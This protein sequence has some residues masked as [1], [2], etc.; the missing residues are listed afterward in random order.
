MIFNNDFILKCIFLYI[1]IIFT[2]SFTSCIFI[3]EDIS[4]SSSLLGE[5]YTNLSNNSNEAEKIYSYEPKPVSQAYKIYNLDGSSDNI[6]VH[7]YDTYVYSYE[8]ESKYLN[9]KGVEFNI[10]IL[11]GEVKIYQYLCNYKKCE[12]NFNSK[13]LNELFPIL[14]YLSFT[15]KADEIIDKLYSKNNNNQVYSIIIHCLNITG[16]NCSYGIKI[17]KIERY[18]KLNNGEKLLKYIK[19]DNAN[20]YI[21]DK[22]IIPLNTHSKTIFDL[23]VYSGDA[24]LLLTDGTYNDYNMD[25]TIQDLGLNQRAI[26]EPKNNDD[27]NYDNISFENKIHVRTNEGAI[28]YIYV[29][30]IPDD[31]ENKEVL[32]MEMTIMYSI[33]NSTNITLYSNLTNEENYY[34][35]FNPINCD[36]EINHFCENEKHMLITKEQNATIEYETMKSSIKYEIKKY[37]Q[38]HIDENKCFFMINSYYYNRNNSYIL[39]PESK[40]FRAI[41]NSDMDTIRMIF[42]FATTKKNPKILLR[43]SLYSLND[44][45]LTI[46]FGS[47]F[48]EQYCSQST[49]ILLSKENI[50]DIEELTINKSCPIIITAKYINNINDNNNN[51]VLDFNIKTLTN[52]P[53]FIKSEEF[54][55]DSVLNNNKQYYMS[56]LKK[57]STGFILLN[58][59]R[60][61]G[62]IYANIYK[63]SNKDEIRD[64]NG[65]II[66]PSDKP[67]DSFN[68]LEQKFFF[69]ESNTKD[70]DE[71]CYLIFGIT[72]SKMIEDETN[73]KNPKDENY[74]SEYSLVLKYLNKNEKI[75]NFIDLI[76][77]EFII[78]NIDDNENDFYQFNFP[79][80][81]NIN[82][83]IIDYQSEN[84]EIILCFNS[85]N[86]FNHD[87]CRTF[88][89]N[90]ENLIFKIKKEEIIS[91]Y[92]YNYNDTYYI[93]KIKIQL[94]N[95]IFKITNFDT[96]YKLRLTSPIDLFEKVATID[97]SLPVHCN[98]LIPT[99]NGFYSDY[100]ININKFQD[101]ELVQLY[102][103]SN[104]GTE[105][106]E[107]Y[108]KI[109]DSYNFLEKII[110]NEIIWPNKENN[111]YSSS[112]NHQPNILK[113]SVNKEQSIKI[114]IR[115]Y[116][117]QMFNIT[118]ITN[119]IRKNDFLFPVSNIKQLININNESTL[120][121][122]IPYNSSYNIQI[123]SIEENA[124]IEISYGSTTRVLM[125][126]DR[127]ILN[128]DKNTKLDKFGLRSINNI[129]NYNT[130]H[131]SDSEENNI[132]FFE[133][134][135]LEEDILLD[136]IEQWNKNIFF[137]EQKKDQLLYYFEVEKV[138]ENI[139]FNLIFNELNTNDK[140]DQR[141]SNSSELF[142]I[143][144]Y[145]I[146]E[147]Q[148]N[149]LKIGK[150]SL[151]DTLKSLEPSFNGNYNLVLHQGNI[152]F[153]KED[154]ANNKD[155]NY[156]L[157]IINKAPVNKRE[158]IFISCTITVFSQSKEQKNYIPSNI[159]LANAF[160]P[161]SQESKHYYY[162]RDNLYNDI[163]IIDFSSTSGKIEIKILDSMKEK[164]KS[165]EIIKRQD[166]IGK[167]LIAIN[168]NNKLNDY[169]ILV[170][171]DHF[172]KHNLYYTLR[173]YSVKNSIDVYPYEYNNNIISKINK[174]NIEITIN[175]IKYNKDKSAVKECNYYARVYRKIN[176]E[177]DEDDDHYESK[178]KYKEDDDDD[179]DDDNYNL[180]TSFK[181]EI[182]ILEQSVFYD[183]KVI[184][185]NPDYL[186]IRLNYTLKDNEKIVIDAMAEIFKDPV[187]KEYLAYKRI[188]P[189]KDNTRKN[190]IYILIFLICGIFLIFCAILITCI[191]CY[192]N[193]NKN[194]KEK[195]DK[196]SFALGDNNPYE[197]IE[198]SVSTSSENYEEEEEDTIY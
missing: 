91:Y 179:D 65:N 77:D 28:Y 81:Q 37:S 57:N 93:I 137:Y 124:Q 172:P 128:I 144:G 135:K 14:G 89:G 29:Q 80:N 11:S 180:I 87:C 150:K 31:K 98:S 34:I 197:K 168:N 161:I 134:S 132:C 25:Y 32:P 53:Y 44:I 88:K 22:Y 187:H 94:K 84:C 156:V 195:V 120:M 175:K 113:F 147:Y 107:I 58:F 115:V 12:I 23:I 62:I 186:T 45:F 20:E 1:L 153:Q 119:L 17:H 131:D 136:E 90:E 48:I 3:N 40:P 159:P 97:T 70:C 154:L 19:K 73:D 189:K 109:V 149:D 33:I 30:I 5:K 7:T 133:Y 82:N 2:F 158:Y 54:F 174:N 95:D 173:Y 41:L 122:N 71:Y 13:K 121:K 108:A 59:K 27:N 21:D 129:K 166:E 111:D 50:P 24:F 193:K 26:F 9:K 36:L 110:N 155:F 125:H 66:L 61:T 192:R 96:K 114:L 148:L 141:D 106:I 176:I 15:V 152:I 100:L 47:N 8:S 4:F 127:F 76:N 99:Y 78:G 51:V 101:Y 190:K 75:S 182:P 194:L 140:S 64:Q 83:L 86:F 139:I 183:D 39:L 63:Y 10:E 167:N 18:K 191:I 188:S 49:D 142:Q 138:D 146:N 74:F 112:N 123:K 160:N 163:T 52:V 116:I 198:R 85:D 56:I 104:G 69:N 181:E 35:I 38:T 157:I 105:N 145:L 143:K 16:N 79:N 92:N 42:P 60:G 184:N 170:E 126:N 67:T 118:L 55:S 6:N 164:I 46:N 117:S 102:A 165:F 130:I 68:Y 171:C 103:S 196:I 177:D 43:I 185:S 178:D 151:N 72:P 162:I 169:I